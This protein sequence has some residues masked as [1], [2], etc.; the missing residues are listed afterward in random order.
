MFLIGRPVKV[1]KL[2][3]DLEVEEA[4]GGERARHKTL[5]RVDVSVR[6]RVDLV[7]HD[8]VCLGKFRALWVGFLCCTVV[9][10]NKTHVSGLYEKRFDC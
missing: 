9:H 2:Y 8:G 10:A 3:A 6:V 4:V 1:E 5:I 7:A